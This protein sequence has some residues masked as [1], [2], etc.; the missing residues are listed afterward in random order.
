MQSK[1]IIEKSENLN[2]VKR[3]HTATHTKRKHTHT[4]TG[5]VRVHTYTLSIQMQRQRLT[6]AVWVTPGHLLAT[7][8]FVTD[9]VFLT[10]SQTGTSG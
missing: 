3:N 7:L 2:K 6:L 10:T 4:K 5:N 9:L 1:F 8:R